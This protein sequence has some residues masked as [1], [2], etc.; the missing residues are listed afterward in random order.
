MSFI[1]RPA[2]AVETG[3]RVL[4]KAI[5][6]LNTFLL[7]MMTLIGASAVIGRYVFNTPIFGAR[8]FEKIILG[9]LIFLG[10]AYTLSQRAHVRADIIFQR[11]PPR[12]QAVLNFA[13]SLLA[14]IPF[15][16][17]T[18]PASVVAL[19]DWECGRLVENIGLPLAPFKLIVIVGSGL[20]CLE[21]IIQM[22]HLVPEMSRRKGR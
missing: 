19:A 20:L 15:A 7:L 8:D 12:M 3:V 22:V 6:H 21:I 17:I 14:L 13:M 16:L 2:R 5:N 9:A 1:T 18:W 10:L 4:E 11:Y